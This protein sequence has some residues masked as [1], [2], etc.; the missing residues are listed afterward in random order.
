MDRAGNIADPISD[1]ILVKTPPTT[2]LDN[3]E[4]KSLLSTEFLILLIVIVIILLILILVGIIKKRRKHRRQ[5]L[6]PAGALTI[7]PGALSTPVVS[8][9]QVPGTHSPDSEPFLIRMANFQ[10]PPSPR[11]KHFPWAPTSG[12]RISSVYSC[13]AHAI[14]WLPAPSL[15]WLDCCW[16]S[17]W[18]P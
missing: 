15:L 5:E 4:K 13:M 14:P 12:A 18:A 7:K 16:G 17:C 2:K 1:V 9:G 3:T 10:C 6:L 8:V 11:Q